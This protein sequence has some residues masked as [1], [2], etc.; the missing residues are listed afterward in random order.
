MTKK[1]KILLIV[2]IVIGLFVVVDLIRYPLVTTAYRLAGQKRDE[3]V[4]IEIWHY[5]KTIRVEDPQ[6]VEEILAS[7]DGYLFRGRSYR[8]FKT[9]GCD[10]SVRFINEE[11]EISDSL[12]PEFYRDRPGI[13][14]GDF[15]YRYFARDD[16]ITVLLQRIWDGTDPAEQESVSNSPTVPHATKPTPTE[17]PVTEPSVTEPPATE[18]PATEA[19]TQPDYTGLSFD[20][21][22]KL[23]YSVKY[24]YDVADLSLRY[25]G[26]YDGCHVA[27]VDT[28]D[29]VPAVEREDEIAGFTFHYNN[30][31]RLN[32]YKDG[33]ILTLTDA[34][35]VGWLSDDAIAQLHSA[36]TNE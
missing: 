4:A 9:T 20:E 31:Q 35:A 10:W 24:G 23:A 33:Q 21:A 22:M 2:V 25:Y 14:T 16:D 18:P 19:P 26:E 13:F 5:G 28:P 34:Y 27:F 12:P 11:G 15:S 7:L 32:V 30:Y 29:G 1:K 36:Y 6:P 8:I 17:P 3:V